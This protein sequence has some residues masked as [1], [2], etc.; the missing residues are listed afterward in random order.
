MVST[1][2]SIISRI[3]GLTF[4]GYH[5]STGPLSPIWGMTCRPTLFNLIGNVAESQVAVRSSDYRDIDPRY[6]TL[7]DW[8]NLLQGVHDRGM[9]LV[10][11]IS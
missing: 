1:Q 3:S 5:P 4:Y 8:D 10:Q 7:A 6:G 11:V 2:N 9:K